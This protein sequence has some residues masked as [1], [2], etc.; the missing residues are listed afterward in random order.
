MWQ[1]RLFGKQFMIIG[2]HTEKREPPFKVRILAD[3]GYRAKDLGYKVLNRGPLLRGRIISGGF[4]NL[5]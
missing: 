1:P 3:P 5:A 4:G 2:S